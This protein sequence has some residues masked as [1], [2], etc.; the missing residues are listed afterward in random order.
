MYNQQKRHGFCIHGVF[1]IWCE[2]GDS[3]PHG[4]TTRTSNVLVYHS[5]T[6]ANVLKY[7]NLMQGICQYF[8]CVTLA[9][10]RLVC[11][12]IGNG[13]KDNGSFLCIG[14]GIGAGGSMPDRRKC[15]ARKGA[16]FEGWR[17]GSALRWGGPRERLRSSFH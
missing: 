11:Y 1:L 12:T 2:R 15:P 8:F 7:Y 3:N 5:N 6:L 4:I 9:I 13:G 17:D 10:W 16:S 14:R